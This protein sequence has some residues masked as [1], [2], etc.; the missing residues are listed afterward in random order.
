ML[1]VGLATGAKPRWGGFGDNPVVM[2][3]TSRNPPLPFPCGVKSSL[4]FDGVQNP[5]PLGSSKIQ[6][7]VF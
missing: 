7:N 1:G 4:H 5:F 3:K 2:Q 6:R